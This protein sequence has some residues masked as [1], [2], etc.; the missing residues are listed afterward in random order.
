MVSYI[1]LLP[2]YTISPDLAVR[3][4]LCSDLNAVQR[5]PINWPRFRNQ[6]YHVWSGEKEVAL[7]CLLHVPTDLAFIRSL[8]SVRKLTT[9]MGVA[10]VPSSAIP[11]IS[12][13]LSFQHVSQFFMCMYCKSTEADS[14]PSTPFQKAYLIKTNNHFFIQRY[15][16]YIYIYIHIH[17]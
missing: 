16:I 13:L 3:L 17:I 10:P 9:L 1:P 15:I 8:I 12:N 2:D 4:S 6:S 7:G 14:F 11:N 5:H